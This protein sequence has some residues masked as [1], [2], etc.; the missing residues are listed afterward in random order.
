[1]CSLCHRSPFWLIAQEPAEPKSP[2]HGSGALGTCSEGGVHECF[3]VRGGSCAKE[4]DQWD[5]HLDCAA[6]EV[7]SRFGSDPSEVG[8]PYPVLLEVA[9]TPEAL[10]HCGVLLA[11]PLRAHPG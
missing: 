7:Q 3:V 11:G 2:L 6:P 9:K 8:A 5:C 4:E 1:M 10:G